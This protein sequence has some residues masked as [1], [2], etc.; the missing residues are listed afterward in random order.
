LSIQHIKENNININNIIPN[1]LTF[2]PGTICKTNLKSVKILESSYTKASWNYIKNSR[3]Y[4]IGYH[5][6]LNFEMF[7]FDS[8]IIESNYS[9]LSS[10]MKHFDDSSLEFKYNESYNGFYLQKAGLNTLELK[11]NN[12]LL[13][14][15]NKG[16]KLTFLDDDSN[17]DFVENEFIYDNNNEIPQFY[18][19]LIPAVKRIS[20]KCH[21]KSL[22]T[23]ILSK[24]NFG[25]NIET[26]RVSTDGIIRVSSKEECNRIIEDEFIHEKALLN[27]IKKDSQAQKMLQKSIKNKKS[28]KKAIHMLHIP[29]NFIWLLVI[30]ALGALVAIMI[31]CVQFAIYNSLFDNFESQIDSFYYIPDQYISLMESVRY[32]IQAISVNEYFFRNKFKKIEKS[33]HLKMYIHQLLLIKNLNKSQNMA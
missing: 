25:Q 16:S 5:I 14:K 30:L 3:N 27:N 9:C 22:L 6:L 19:S 1:I 11:A 10:S 4:I 13:K 8:T 33:Y 23:Q 12:L 29:M 15:S 32:I 7:N 24:K 21:D 2:A 17:K 18:K 28:I 26:Y 20:E 31:V